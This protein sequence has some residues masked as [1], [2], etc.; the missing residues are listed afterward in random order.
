MFNTPISVAAGLLLEIGGAG[1]G[2]GGDPAPTRVRRARRKARGPSLSL[3][4]EQ[5]ASPGGGKP[6]PRQARIEAM[7]LLRRGPPFPYSAPASR[8]V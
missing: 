2:A 3:F 7:A 4:V 5:P 8:M 6:V 1:S